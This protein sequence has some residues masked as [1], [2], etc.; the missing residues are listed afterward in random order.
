MYLTDIQNTKKIMRSIIASSGVHW[1]MYEIGGIYIESSI[2]NGLIQL[3]IGLTGNQRPIV[4]PEG[5]NRGNLAVPTLG[6]DAHIAQGLRGIIVNK[7][8]LCCI[9][10]H[11]VPSEQIFGCKHVAPL[12]ISSA[13]DCGNSC[14]HFENAVHNISVVKSGRILNK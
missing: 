13:N 10:P 11:I 3:G 2:N 14:S 8:V 9:V 7:G 12:W 4:V 1:A 5:K 6:R